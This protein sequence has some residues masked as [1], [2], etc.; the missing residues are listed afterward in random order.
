MTMDPRS[1]H[2]RW[3]KDKPARTTRSLIVDCPAS[4]T[5]AHVLNLPRRP[6]IPSSPIDSTTALACE[7][8]GPSADGSLSNLLRREVP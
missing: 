8:V 6:P 1:C 5:P 3:P 4:H 7:A 2:E